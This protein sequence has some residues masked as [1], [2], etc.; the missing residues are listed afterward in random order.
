MGQDSIQAPNLSRKKCPDCGLVN[1][2]SDEV[3]RRCGTA[4]YEEELT[5]RF[6]ATEVDPVKPKKRPFVKRVI[7]IATTTGVVLA[8]FYASLLF[9]SD[10]LNPDQRDK[11]QRAITLI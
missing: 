1:A 5:D 9:S 4:F 10:G 6:H 8:V 2:G 7:W 11:V 3:C